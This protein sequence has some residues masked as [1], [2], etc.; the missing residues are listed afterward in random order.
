MLRKSLYFIVLVIFGAIG[1]ALVPLEGLPGWAHRIAPATPT[2]WAMR[3]FR[4]V[5]LSGGSLG[6]QLLPVVVLAAMS[7]GL[8]LVVLARFRLDDAKIAF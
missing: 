8:A 3:G 4:S 7:T 1:G 2:Y 6:S 5:I